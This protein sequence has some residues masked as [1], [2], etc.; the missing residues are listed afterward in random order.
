MNTKLIVII[1]VLGLSLLILNNLTT[2]ENFEVSSLAG[3]LGNLA[4]SNDISAIQENKADLGD[5]WNS[6][7]VNIYNGNYV[8]DIDANKNT[9]IELLEINL[10]KSQNTGEI[11]ILERQIVQRKDMSNP[12]LTPSCASLEADDLVMPKGQSSSAPN[13]SEANI[14]DT[15]PNMCP[16]SNIHSYQGNNVKGGYCCSVPP[17]SSGTYGKDVLDSCPSGNIKKCAKPP[18]SSNTRPNFKTPKTSCGD[19]KWDIRLKESLIATSK[20]VQLCGGWCI[21][22]KYDSRIIYSWNPGKGTFDIN[23]TNTECNKWK[24]NVYQIFLKIQEAEG[25]NLN[26][27]TETD[28]TILTFKDV[29]MVNPKILYS[30]SNGMVL[31]I[32]LVS[33]KRPIAIKVSLYRDGI[34]TTLGNVNN[35]NMNRRFYKV[36]SGQELAIANYQLTTGI[37]SLKENEYRQEV[38]NMMKNNACITKSGFSGSL[39]CYQQLF[40]QA[41]CTEAEGSDYANLSK[42]MSMYNKQTPTNA[43]KSFMKEYTTAKTD[44]NSTDYS[45][46]FNAT[47]RCSGKALA[48][49][50]NPCSDYYDDN[51]DKL[52]NCY[53]KGETPEQSNVAMQERIIQEGFTAHPNTSEWPKGSGNFVKN[54]WTNL[55]FNQAQALNAETVPLLDNDIRSGKINNFSQ[56]A[57]SSYVKNS[58]VVNNDAHQTHIDLC[59]PYFTDNVWNEADLKSST[60]LEIQNEVM[61]LP[62]G[63]KV[64]IPTVVTVEVPA[65]DTRK[66][67]YKGNPVNQSILEKVLSGIFTNYGQCDVPKQSNLN[68]NIVPSCSN[69]NLMAKQTDPPLPADVDMKK[70]MCDNPPKGAPDFA[71]PKTTCNTPEWNDRLKQSLIAYSLYHSKPCSEWC[72]PDKYDPRIIYSWIPSKGA[73]DINHPECDKWA[74]DVK[75]AFQTMQDNMK[76]SSGMCPKEQPFAYQGNNVKGGFC[77]PK[78][79]VSS[80]NYGKNVLDSCPGGNYVKCENPP[81]KNYISQLAESCKIFFTNLIGGGDT[82]KINT[83]TQYAIQFSKVITGLCF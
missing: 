80:G 39:D 4:S 22:D 67:E 57:M 2:K 24:S 14:C 82:R 42:I 77:C 16:D 21:P 40:K 68:P 76:T 29:K 23:N 75:K 10:D 41:G 65:R 59:S 70:F 48:D 58:K 64:N 66:A 19:P 27:T 17:T 3:G 31:I 78:Q 55:G 6:A 36:Q 32:E 45:T 79:P 1:L 8:I 18:C 72:L 53:N 11:K 25:V 69:L 63:Q 13:M 44:Q 26:E 28:I 47:Q 5:G 9:K 35:K 50:L 12:N 62:G 83:V 81:C 43:Y 73:F 33:M 54:V 52:Y 20:V 30:E 56:C 71:N 49:E 61:N 38:D 60:M 7:M 34:L 37:Q 51:A 15:P 74:G 46:A